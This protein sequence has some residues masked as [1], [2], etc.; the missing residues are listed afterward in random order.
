LYK[1]SVNGLTIFHDTEKPV[2][3]PPVGLTEAEPSF[4]PK[5]ETLFVVRFTFI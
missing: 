4:K 5:H 3:E 1:E 2:P